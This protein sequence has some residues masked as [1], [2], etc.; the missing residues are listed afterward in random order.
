M[1]VADPLLAQ[2]EDE[3]EREDPIPRSVHPTEMPEHRVLREIF[4]HYT[5]FRDY[6]G[7]G[8]SPVLEHTYLVPVEGVPSECPECPRTSKE[9]EALGM[10]CVYCG[11][12]MKR[13]SVSFNFWD[14]H[15]GLKDLA[16]RKRE[17]V[18]W[19]VIYDQKQKDVAKKMGIT[20]VTVGQYVE[21]AFRSLIGMHLMD[22]EELPD[23]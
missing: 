16:P 3:W 20:T 5:E 6:V 21:H 4:R 23:V 1:S 22:V 12:R 15:R 10:E 9:H 7:Q 2:V 11:G 17:A 14:I 19:N 8:N 13:V 18:L